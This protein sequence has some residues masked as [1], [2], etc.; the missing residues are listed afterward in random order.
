MLD[1][2]GVGSPI[3]DLLARVP[4]EFLATIN[5]EKGGMLLVESDLIA[6]IVKRLPEPPRQAAG[7]SS[8][9][10]TAAVARLGLRTAFVGKLGND[11][12]AQAYIRQAAANGTDTTRF[13]KAEL[14]NACCLSL[15]T[16]DGQ[17]TMRTCLAAAMTLGPREITP[18][19]FAGCRHAHVEG[20]LLFN[21]A[22]ATAVL[23]SARAAGCTISVDLASFEVVRAAREWILDQLREGIDIIFANEDEITA[24]YPENVGG[25]LSTDDY[26]TLAQRLAAEGRGTLAAVKMGADGAWIAQGQ[27]LHRIAPVKAHSIDSTGAGDAWAGAFLFGHL[28]GWDIPKSGKLA[29]QLGAEIVQHIGATLPDPDWQ[30]LRQKI[31]ANEI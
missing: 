30:T 5:G 19:D 9:N 31:D 18:E 12:T 10:T 28:K 7:G 23:Q 29:S 13:K 24:L 22:L 1:L 2:I 4:D 8:A 3:M 26:G 6:D 20:Y 14:P 25:T 27:T 21:P 17:R 15:I 16:P 11:E